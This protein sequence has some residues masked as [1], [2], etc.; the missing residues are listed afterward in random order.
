MRDE[1]VGSGFRLLLNSNTNA[2]SKDPDAIKRMKDFESGLKRL[3]LSNLFWNFIDITDESDAENYTINQLFHQASFECMT[4]IG[5]NNGYL[6]A[7]VEIS[8][9][10]YT[11]IAL[12]E[13]RIKR[14]FRKEYGLRIF[15]AKRFVNDSKI[16][17]VRYMTKGKP[18]RSK[19]IIA[20]FINFNGGKLLR[21]DQY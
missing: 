8:I 3:F 19:P 4:E 1:V 6:H 13:D 14:W 2:N 11:S 7:H 16:Y 9:I 15:S 12:N 20:N 18:K 21:Y 5:E 17:S 10:H